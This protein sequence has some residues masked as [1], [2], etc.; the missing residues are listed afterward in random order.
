MALSRQMVFRHTARKQ[1]AMKKTIAV[2]SLVL[3]STSAV[4]AQDLGWP[5]QIIKEGSTLVYYQ[6]QV[7]NWSNFQ[8]L[9]WRMAI[10][11]TPAGGKATVGAVRMHGWTSVNSETQMVLI[12][13]LQV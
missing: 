13:N 4:F 2:C 9:D 10:S 8:Q 6:P 1:G 7:E 3:A 11:I 5:R 12:S